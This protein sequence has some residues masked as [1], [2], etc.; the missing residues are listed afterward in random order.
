MTHRRT[1]EQN[2]AI[3]DLVQRIIGDPQT[4]VERWLFDNAPVWVLQ[5]F[6]SRVLDHAVPMPP[7]ITLLSGRTIDISAVINA[8]DRGLYHAV[9]VYND[10]RSDN[11]KNRGDEGPRNYSCCTERITLESNPCLDAGLE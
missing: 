6:A 1:P 2:K 11:A 4:R 3:A 8:L 5:E 9:L 7:P 10:C